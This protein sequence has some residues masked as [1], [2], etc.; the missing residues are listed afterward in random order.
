MVNLTS[1]NIWVTSF[2][3]GTI[4]YSKISIFL[5]YCANNGNLS[6]I[7]SIV[8]FEGHISD[9]L[10]VSKEANDIIG[11]RKLFLPFRPPQ[12]IPVKKKCSIN[13]VKV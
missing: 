9:T 7:N 12:N 8:N 5:R 11:C 3:I 6:V 1:P 10:F 13:I 2:I 4:L